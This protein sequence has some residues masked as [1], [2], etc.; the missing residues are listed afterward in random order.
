MRYLLLTTILLTS[1]L[2]ACSDTTGSD[3]TDDPLPPRPVLTDYPSAPSPPD[4]PTPT[5]EPALGRGVDTT[6]GS[7][8]LKDDT[9]FP[10]GFRAEN[11]SGTKT[12]QFYA[13]V[14]D[15]PDRRVKL[16]YGI[17][18]T[19]EGLHLHAHYDDI[20]RANARQR[21]HTHVIRIESVTRGTRAI[22]QDDNQTACT[23][24][25]DWTPQQFRQRCGTG[26]VSFE[27]MGGYII[28]SRP[29]DE[30]TRL[31]H[32]Q[33]GYTLELDAT[34]DDASNDPHPALTHTSRPNDFHV[35]AFGFEPPAADLFEDEQFSLADALTVL[36][37]LGDA[38]RQALDQ[39]KV[40]D[41]ACGAV[42]ERHVQKYTYGQYED[43]GL[44]SYEALDCYSELQRHRIDSDRRR[45]TLQ[46]IAQRIQWKL[47]HRD[48]VDW[49]ASTES[50]NATYQRYDHFAQYLDLCL[51]SPT[52]QT[53][54]SCQSSFDSPDTS[55]ANTCQACNTP[56]V[57]SDEDTRCPADLRD[58][59]PFTRGC[60]LPDIRDTY[61]N[62][63]PTPVTTPTN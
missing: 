63:P 6:D 1:L 39:N 38:Y 24:S 27:R 54:Q 58:A 18:S 52:D 59:F 5:D 23:T 22:N 44:S 61:R 35:T 3:D 17:A 28:I 37:R 26:Y 9:C 53:T 46:N 34:Q 2:P 41:K 13:D 31:D 60:Y 7:L 20:V 57:C 62:L 47:D 16:R 29:L 19:L 40:F 32:S 4:Y 36:N 14:A 33:N 55:A 15:T 49:K 50:A 51:T 10:A 56:R 43:C 25:Q 42:L 30:I 12:T 11:K 48:R 8:Q 45:Y 21:F